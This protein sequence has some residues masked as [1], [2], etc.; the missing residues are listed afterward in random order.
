MNNKQGEFQEKID[1]QVEW[2]SNAEQEMNQSPEAYVT[3][4]KKQK[5]NKRKSRFDKQLKI[6]GWLLLGLFIIALPKL[7]SVNSSSA[8]NAAIESGIS[9]QLPIGVR[10]SQ[11]D[12]NLSHQDLTIKHSSK[13]AQAKIYVWDYAAEDGDY[14][15]VLV[16]GVAITEPF[17]IKNK[18][19][20]FSVPTV[21]EVQ[22]LGIRDG[23]GG[24]TYAVHYEVNGTTYFN[25]TDVGKGN[26]YTL[27]R[28]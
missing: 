14:V 12:T 18:P 28:E 22:I 26:N 17:M 16:D 25:G 27:I 4:E 2:D 13:E 19:V 24:I 1:N 10:I 23:G 20:V 21:G 7:A 8:A 11:S 3:T 15:Q 5:R 6:T 9:S